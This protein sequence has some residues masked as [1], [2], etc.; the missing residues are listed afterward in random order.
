MLGTDI[1]EDSLKMPGRFLDQNPDLSSAIQLK[2]QPDSNHIFKNIIGPEDQF[3]FSM[4]NPPFHDSEESAMKGNIR[5][6]KNLKKGKQK[7]YSILEAS[8]RNYGVKE[9]KLL[10][11]PI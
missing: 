6:T 1:N 7:H 11:L 4:C 9:V 3:T 2:Q 8:S 10:L 5:K